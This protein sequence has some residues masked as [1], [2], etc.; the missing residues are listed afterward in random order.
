MESLAAVL[1]LQTQSSVLT[2]L[3]A[4]LKKIRRLGSMEGNSYNSIK[5]TCEQIKENTILINIAQC[6]YVPGLLIGWGL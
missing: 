3:V 4:H 6:S 1:K 5:T 2:V